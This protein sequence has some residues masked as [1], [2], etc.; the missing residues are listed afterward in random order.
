MRLAFESERLLLRPLAETDWDLGIELLTD[1]AVMKYVGGAVT[2]ERVM[3]Q[4][5]VVTRRCAGG[6]IG[7]WCVIEKATEQKLGTSVLLPLPIEEDDTNWDLVAGDDLPDC[8]IEIGYILRPSV[9]GKGYA[10]EAATRLLKFAFEETPL[11]EIVATTDTGN[12]ASQ[13]VLE[14]CGLVSE[15]LR[16]AYAQQSLGFR[17]T[18]RQWVARNQAAS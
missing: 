16:R 7:I 2:R 11:E 4:M 5:P 1:P 17:I 14:K 6:S 3:E 15:G 8:E 12:T 13:R 18:R 9:W 10:T